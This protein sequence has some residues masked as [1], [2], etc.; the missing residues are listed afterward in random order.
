MENYTLSA[1][2]TILFRGSA[3]LLPNGK[4]DKKGEYVD[5]LLTNLNIV[6]TITISKLFS[7]KVETEVYSVSNVKFYDESAQIIRRKTTV[8]VY[9]TNK[10]LF[11]EFDKEKEAKEFCDKALKLVSG[12]SKL[13]RAVKKTQKAINE[14]NEALDINIVSMAKTGATIAATAAVE[15]G[16]MPGAGKATSFI[17]KVA[18][19]ILKNKK[20][21]SENMLPEQKSN[22]E[23]D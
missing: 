19:V 7:K 17:G 4:K 23:N 1:N 20:N 14:T 11:I 22:E 18:G 13:V 10:E 9:L 21:N 2:E 8:D 3:T 12:Q 16:G 5:V 15:V 6:L